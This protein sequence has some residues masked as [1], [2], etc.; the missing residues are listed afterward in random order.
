MYYIIYEC[1]RVG[2]CIVNQRVPVIIS[3]KCLLG[4][5]ADDNGT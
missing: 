5:I 4:G 3:A 1:G 2:V